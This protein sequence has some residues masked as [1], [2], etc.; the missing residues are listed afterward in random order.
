MAGPEA[1]KR[2]QVEQDDGERL[3]IWER[4]QS[5]DVEARALSS[6]RTEDFVKRCG[7]HLTCGTVCLTVV[8]AAIRADTVHEERPY[9]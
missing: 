2:A 8:R 3:R 5:S 9:T 6:R 1:R 7:R 4:G